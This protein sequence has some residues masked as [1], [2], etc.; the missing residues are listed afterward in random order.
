MNR[1]LHATHFTVRITTKKTIVRPAA[2]PRINTPIT[3]SKTSHRDI[4]L[5]APH[6]PSQR[7]NDDSQRAIAVFVSMPMTPRGGE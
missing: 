4:V 3:S 2:Q 1:T 7:T 6:H 5:T